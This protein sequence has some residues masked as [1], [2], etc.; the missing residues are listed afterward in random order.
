MKSR[1]VIVLMFSIVGVLVLSRCNFRFSNSTV[2]LNI[3]AE[4]FENLADYHF[5]KDNTIDFIPNERVIPYDLNSSLFSDYA[6]KL[7]FIYIPEG[8]KAL[9][10]DTAVIDFPE[11]SCI[12]KTFYY[13]VDFRNK[14]LGR[15][16][17]ETRLLVRRKSG[18]DALPYIWNE[19]QTEAT[20]EI[21]GGTRKVSWIDAAGQTVNLDYSIPNKNQCKNCH[22]AEGVFSPIGPKV[23]NLNKDFTYADTT[24]NQLEHWAGLGIFG[25]LKCP[26]LKPKNPVW[27]DPTTGSLQDRAP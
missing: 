17:M 21:A 5:F 22:V 14:D 16:V 7:R 23:R 1:I 15:K 20:L 6:E 27:N 10:N 11:G 24:E 9:Y 12:I 4:P 26:I 2:S 3:D 18:W 13:P 8:K 25:G 19:E